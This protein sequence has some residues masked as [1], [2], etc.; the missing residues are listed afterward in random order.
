VINS[1]NQSVELNIEREESSANYRSNQPS[2]YSNGFDLKP[3]LKKRA[4]N[5]NERELASELGKKKLLKV[6]PLASLN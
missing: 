3:N 5:N 6:S 1:E 2:T 4:M